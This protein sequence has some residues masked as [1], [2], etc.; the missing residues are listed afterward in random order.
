M[1]QTPNIRPELQDL[2]AYLDGELPDEER[3]AVARRL[4][5]DPGL[6]DQLTGVGAEFDVITAL[7]RGELEAEAADVH[8]ARFEQIW[9][10]VDRELDG[11][12][13]AP[14]GAAPTAW[15]RIAAFVR[16]SRIPLSLAGAGA[17]AALVVLVT[18][19]TPGAT[20][21][22]HAPS[23]ESSSPTKAT[24]E[25][26]PTAPDTRLAEAVPTEPSLPEPLPAPESNEADVE[27]IEFGG[28][29]GRI[30][31]IEGVRGTT[32][33]IWIEEDEEPIDS[34]RSL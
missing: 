23:T 26:E 11:P 9:D 12:V 31:K 7:V 6:A 20:V 33:V 18:A 19:N 34:E 3:L 24:P 15:G 13:V 28:A 14:A 21:A 2:Q 4:E 22:E 32:T 5:A 29:S 27:R 25:A 1:T 8:E 16:A 17:V 10:A 30:S